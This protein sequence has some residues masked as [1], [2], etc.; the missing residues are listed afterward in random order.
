MSHANAVGL[1]DGGNDGSG[2]GP[3]VRRL[4]VLHVV[5]V[6]GVGGAQTYVETVALGLGRLGYR[7]AVAC[8]DDPALVARCAAVADVFP[9]AVPYGVSPWRDL[10][11][12]RH[13]LGFLR[14]ERFDIVQTSAVKASLYGRLA[15]RLAGVPVVIFTAHGF[16]FHEY[17]HPVLR[18]AL[19]TLERLMSR[20]CTDM[21]V[22]VSEADRRDAVAAGIVPPGRITTIQNGIDV[23]PSTPEGP[24][25]RR[26]LGLDARAPVVGM[27]GRLARQ[28]APGDFLRAAALVAREFPA[29]TFLVVGDGPL[30]A[31]LE[32]LARELGIADRVRF[33]GF[34]DEVPVVL[35]ALDVFALSSLWEGLP[36]TILE[37]M[38]A[39]KPVVA[40]SVNGVAEVVQHGR[41]GWLVSPQQVEQ[42]AAHIVTLLR[43][44][45]IAR[46]MGEA[47]RRR[48]RERFSI[49][50]TV[51]ELSDLY[52]DLYEA[53]CH[54]DAGAAAQHGY[55]AQ[56]TRRSLR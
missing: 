30:R 9:L 16:P 52:Q 32:G 40:T 10:R 51:A 50:R 27:V 14:R 42:L 21:V 53:K 22:S 26:A 56:G 33:L 55:G 18:G 25:A 19:Q 11:Y 29:A 36:L 4:R 2:T 15:A 45:G 46:S 8:N 20:W 17:M 3:A 7:V 49:E 6:P 12:F 39:G 48:V 13:L 43:D 44:P 34:R 37:A 31:T 38:A 23:S 5:S 41:T 47:G 28:K 24:A 35:A 54:A 1:A